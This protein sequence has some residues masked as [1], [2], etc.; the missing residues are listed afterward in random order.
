[1]LEVLSGAVS[2]SEGARR[3]GLSRNHFQ[4]LMHRGLAGM[5]DALQAK[6]SGRPAIPEKQKELAEEAE[7]LRRENKRLQE[8]VD[9]TDRLLEVASGF[10]QGRIKPAGRARRTKTAKSPEGTSDE[11]DDPDGRRRRLEG[12]REMRSI[13]LQGRIASAIVGASAATIT[14][15]K[16]RDRRGLA[17]ASRTQTAS[18]AIAPALLE[19]VEGLVRESH[20]LIGADA[21]RN[22]VPGVSRRSAGRIKGHTCRRMEIERIA[23][24][25]RVAVLRPDVIRGLDAMDFRARGDGFVLAA[26]DGC[27][28]YRTSAECFERYDTDSVEQILVEDIQTNGAPLV[29]RLDRAK[30]HQQARIRGLLEEAGSLIL[31]GPAYLARFY[32]QLERQNRDH[33]AWVEGLLPGEP[34]REACRR[35][36]WVMNE[37]WPRRTLG[38]KTPGEIWR[39]RS[40]LNV[41]RRELR[42]EVRDRAMRIRRH[43]GDHGGPADMAGRLA[44]EQTLTKR[45]YLKREMGGWC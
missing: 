31:H 13:G 9:T 43:L 20:G 30:C 1:V 10:L 25:N 26:A 8:R 19:R 24:L 7:R 36:L 16:A 37:R 44:I 14:R 28:P 42:E 32:G 5:V 29:Y 41:D 33:R 2:V 15:W 40:P 39:D 11:P 21:L 4:T 12:Y 3:L 22:A 6:P 38:W 27:I 23:S 35:M 45:G 34:L 18:S 17:L